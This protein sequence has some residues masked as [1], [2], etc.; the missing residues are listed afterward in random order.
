MPNTAVA[1]L[2]STHPGPAVAVTLIAIVLAV[3][4]GLDGWRLAVLGVAFA[5]NQASV[6]LSN[7][8]IDA[9][10]DIAVGR[11]DKPVALGWVTAS[12][13]RGVAIATAIVAVAATVPLGW[14]ATVAHTV[15]IASAWSYNAWLKRT[16]FSVLPYIVS[17]GLL[18]AV[19]TLSLPEPS[20]AA[21]WAM[22]LGALLGVAAHFA[23]VLPDLD[24]DRATGVRGLPHRLG[25]RRTG[26]GTF[27]AL[28]AA[29]VLALVGPGEVDTIQWLGFSATVLIA[30]VGV[31]LVL[32]REP[33]RLLFQLIIAAAFVNVVLLATAG[34]SLL[35]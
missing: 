7:D 22:G 16:P 21:A 1:L 24:D 3:G 14:R 17:F 27:A 19:V 32:T 28:L 29:S 34:A 9:E 30:A 26:I 35:A 4:V 6:G 31:S 13:V 12:T 10:R 18:P 25:S 5:A 23:N 33:S 2:R 11:T 8:W 15:F 20:W